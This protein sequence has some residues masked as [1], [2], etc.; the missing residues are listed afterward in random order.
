MYSINF[1][2]SAKA[3][4]RLQSKIQYSVSNPLKRSNQSIFTE[5]NTK[6][7]NQKINKGKY[8]TYTKTNETTTPCRTQTQCS[9][10][11]TK[12]IEAK[13]KAVLE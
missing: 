8:K 4:K 6:P 3:H 7:H 10:K 12:I 1:V 9:A 5:R 2:E 13:G 11:H